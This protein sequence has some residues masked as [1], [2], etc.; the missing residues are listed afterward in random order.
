MYSRGRVVQ[1]PYTKLVMVQL[2]HVYNNK[3]TCIAKIYDY[4]F[5]SDKRDHSAQLF[6][7]VPAGSAK[8]AL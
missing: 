2:L 6:L 3:A 8:R 1:I 5:V 7:A 4:L